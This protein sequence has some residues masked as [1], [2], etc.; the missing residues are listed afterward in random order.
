[1]DFTGNSLPLS[2]TGLG[3]ALDV[4]G[5]GA[6]EAWTVLTVETG[7]CGF[8]RDRRP[9]ILFERHIFHHQTGGRFD[10]THPSISS[11]RPG[12]YLGGAREYD[13]LQEAIALSRTAALNSTSWGM[14]QIMGFNAGLAGF[15]SAEEMVGAMMNREDQHLVA[16]A[17]FLRA[18]SLHKALAAHDWPAFARGYN[19]AD[20]AKNQY[21]ARLGA[22]YRRLEQ[23][24]L[25][26]LTT[27]QAQM[28]LMFL[29][30][31]PGAIDGI[32]GR[33]TRSAVVRFRQ[34]RGLP[35]SD[36]IDD[37]LVVALLASVGAGGVV[38]PA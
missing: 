38:A 30:I 5:V 34:E 36:A 28:L 21:D 37:Q 22:A 26:D 10:L 31:D 4:L 8:L 12:G 18:R 33:R 25:P 16:M 11:P 7:G 29:D 32:A 23:G 14:A 1:M 24:P 15:S 6:E 19:G 9:L 13:R 27:R 3:E 35:V 2:S 17:R 20:F